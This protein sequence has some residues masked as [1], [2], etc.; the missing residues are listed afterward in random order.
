MFV[1]TPTLPLVMVESVCLPLVA[2][3]AIVARSPSIIPSMLPQREL[4]AGG[5]GSNTIGLTAMSPVLATTL[6]QLRCGRRASPRDQRPRL[7]RVYEV[8]ATG[9]EA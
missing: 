2:K 9:G 8:A 5:H 6:G 4:A 7:Q 3:V 1:L